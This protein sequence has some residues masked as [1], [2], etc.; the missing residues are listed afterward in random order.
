LIV[1]NE[2]YKGTHGLWRLL[3]NPD[4]K[5]DKDTRESWW[6]NRDNFMEKDYNLYKEILKKTHSI[7]IMIQN[8]KNK[9]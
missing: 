1:N 7:K 6:A 5:L 2:R 3:T 9:V 8:K 4:K